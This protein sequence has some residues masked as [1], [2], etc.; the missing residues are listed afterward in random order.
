MTILHTADLHL[1]GVDDVRW[2]AFEVVMQKARERSADAVV[3]SGD[4]FDRSVD[5]H[6]LKTELRGRFERCPA[7]IILLPGNHDERGLRPGDFFGDNVVVMAGGQVEVTV[8][9][10]HVVGVPY[11]EGGIDET[12]SRLRRAATRR[13]RGRTNV[14]LY[15]GELLDLIPDR[16]AFGEE[17]GNDY[18]PVRLASFDG[19]GF[20]Y[21]LAGHFHRAFAVHRFQDGYF[22]YPG[23]PVS[24]TRRETGRRHV[25]IVTPGEPPVAEPLDTYHA[26]NVDVVLSP[27]EDAHPVEQVERALRDLHPRADAWVCV[28][29]FANLARVGM[30]EI[31]FQEAVQ[32]AAARHNVRELDSR[33]SDVAEIVENELFKRFDR[34]LRSSAATDEDCDAVCNL[35]IR[36]MTEAM[37]AR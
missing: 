25:C 15:H 4:L 16:G 35:V 30:S 12:L 17:T 23:S 19:L 11:Q 7:R 5:A 3:I 37:Y 31:E 33:W 24:V 27:F 26:V 1:R 2:H 18:M 9:D 36:A 34:K 6:A 13:Q 14:L 20:D 32:Q 10:V 29:G 22:V 28:S 8:G 21:V